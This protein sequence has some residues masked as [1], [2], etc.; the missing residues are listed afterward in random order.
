M[1]HNVFAE[2]AD[3]ILLYI[4]RYYSQTIPF[5]EEITGSH[6]V[7]HKAITTKDGY[8][9]SPIAEYMYGGSGIINEQT[10]K[11]LSHASIYR[12]RYPY[13][14]YQPGMNIVITTYEDGQLRLT[15]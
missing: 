14:L 2:T 9:D 10:D 5:T 7:N 11:R 12:Y 6:S 4:R 1:H 13:S 8:L 3:E 15:K